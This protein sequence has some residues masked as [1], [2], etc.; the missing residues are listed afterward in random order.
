MNS[1]GIVYPYFSTAIGKLFL[2]SIFLFNSLPS[3]S[4]RHE[5]TELSLAT[6]ITVLTIVSFDHVLSF[7]YDDQAKVLGL[8]WCHLSSI[9]PDSIF[10]KSIRRGITCFV[11]CFPFVLSF[12]VCF[13]LHFFVALSL[14]VCFLFVCLFCLFVFCF[15]NFCFP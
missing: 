4:L 13:F 7:N 1:N 6:R 3:K 5:F 15:F 12:F 10:H 9:M 14:F 11:L 2:I 8:T